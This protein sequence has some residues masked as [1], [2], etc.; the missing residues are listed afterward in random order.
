MSDGAGERDPGRARSITRIVAWLGSLYAGRRLFV[1]LGLVVMLFV[2]GH[3]V[4]AFATLARVALLAVVVLFAL[5]VI[6]L[7]RVRAGVRSRREMP[8]RLSNG[9]ENVIRIFVENGY[10]FPLHAEVIEELPFQ[11]QIRD[12]R[13]VVRV[14]PGEEGRIRYTVRPVRRGV[15]GFGAVVVMAASPL[16]LAVR[17]YRFDEGRE[18]PVYPSFLQMRKYELLAVSNRLEEAGVKKV[19]R[20]GHT[21]EF[22]HI[23]EY[24]VGDDVRTV[25]W[26]A[27]ARRGGLMVNRYR[28]ERAQPVYCILDTGRLMKMPFE[29]MTL[30]DHSIN[31][32]LV[33]AN[34]ALLK[35]D[36][37]G[38]ITFSHAIGP[39][40]PARR[41]GG[42][43]YR[44]QEVLHALETDF[45]ETDYVVLLTYLRRYVRRRSLL[46]IFTNFETLSGMRR[47]LPYLR[48]IARNHVVV[49]VFFEN[50]ELRRLLTSKPA[51]VEGV[52]VKTI[53]EK[54]AYEKREIV[55]ELNR[56]GIHAILTPPES[57][58]V[59][60]LNRYL[61]LKA[62]GVV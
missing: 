44:F 62:Q 45:L 23:R 1:A 42:Q 29:E 57:L 6:A 34:I 10:P 19:R 48:A 55:R 49:P 56:H 52:Y 37:A 53:A 32:A 60:T 39:V 21:M 12:A 50:T 5:D 15:Y 61:A 28:E 2:A 17:R 14:S 20:L 18:V 11:F 47:Q 58:T 46:L 27:T 25:N 41:K 22:D 43:I 36:R 8:D 51:D 59:A 4:P 38:L 31:A 40:L 13:Y 26:R 30:L 7:F 35:E 33:L 3:F 54:L 24:V 16:R 9:D